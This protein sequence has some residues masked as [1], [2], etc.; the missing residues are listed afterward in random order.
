MHYA[1]VLKR[2]LWRW[3]TGFWRYLTVME[4]V[5]SRLLLALP[6][7][8]HLTL[9]LPNSVANTTI[10]TSPSR[11]EAHRAKKSETYQLAPGQPI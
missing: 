11:H 1:P 8:W 6:S 5:L 4:E 7:N 2:Q 10:D 3:T 9:R